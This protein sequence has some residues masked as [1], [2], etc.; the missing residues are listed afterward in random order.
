MDQN[1]RDF[2]ASL[3]FP[4]GWGLFVPLAA[5][6]LIAVLV[7]VRAAPRDT[8]RAHV[9]GI[10]VGSVIGVLATVLMVGNCSATGLGSGYEL[11]LAQP[12]SYL[13]TLLLLIGPLLVCPG[14]PA[15]LTLVCLS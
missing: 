4:P 14:A 5:A 1:P 8:A 9:R 2:V 15:L 7:A 10:R 6:L 13:A 3:L 11:I 12:L